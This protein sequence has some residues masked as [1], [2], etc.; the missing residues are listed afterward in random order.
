MLRYNDD[1]VVNNVNITPYLT[2]CVFG[3]NKLWGKD[4]G[5]NTLSGKY[6]GT[7]IGVFA[8]FDCTFG[9]L[10]Q[11]EIEY[12][13]PILD[14]AYQTI[15]YYDPYKKN[16]IT[17]QTY[18]GD[19]QLEQNCLFSDVARAGKSFQISFVATMKRS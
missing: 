8:K 3:Y 16:K 11:S 13:T 7:L 6:T 10:T 1:L 9:N 18:S 5:R 15:T 17:I 14:S 4:T 2:N 12:L 19:W